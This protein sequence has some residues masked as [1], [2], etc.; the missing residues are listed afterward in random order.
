MRNDFY[1]TFSSPQNKN[2]YSRTLLRNCGFSPNFF[3][4]LEENLLALE[5]CNIKRIK[6]A[7]DINLLEF[8]EENKKNKKIYEAEDKDIFDKNK[9]EFKKHIYLNCNSNTSINNNYS[10]YTTIPSQDCLNKNKYD[11]PNKKNKS[12]YFINAYKSRHKMKFSQFYEI[13]SITMENKNKYKLYHKC[14]YPGCNRTFSSSGWLKAHLKIHL[15]QIHNSNYC[16]L[17][18]K[19]LYD[20]INTFK[21]EK[22]F[23]YDYNNNIVNKISIKNNCENISVDNS[24]N[25][26]LLYSGF[27]SPSL[28]CSLLKAY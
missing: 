6:S 25:S 9:I 23:F 21:K 4:D 24:K 26:F 13:N 27:N 19:F 28:S 22:S 10:S 15:K 3:L 1:E 18:E 12:K 7:N 20:K 17:F 5:K 14:C 16:K 2:N 8:Q 11:I